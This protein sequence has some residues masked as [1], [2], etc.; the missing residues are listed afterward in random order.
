MFWSGVDSVLEFVYWFLVDRDLELA[1]LSGVDSGRLGSLFG[2]DFDPELVSWAGIDFVLVL[3][4][5]FGVD[6]DLVLASLSV[7]DC[8]LVLEFLSAVDSGLL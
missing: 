3:V 6:C 1:S 8:D 5:W 2:F 7:I 4:F